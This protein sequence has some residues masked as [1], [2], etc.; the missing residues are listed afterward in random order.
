MLERPTAIDPLTLPD[1]AYLTPQDECFYFGEYSAR[2]GYTHSDTNSLILNLKK[3]VSRRGMTDYHYKDEAIAQVATAI[4]RF[5]DVG[6]VTFVP[7]P[8]SK[9]RTD[10][11]YDDRLIRILAACQRQNAQVDYR[12]LLTQTESTTAAHDGTR[13]RPDQLESIYRVQ[14]VETPLRGTVVLLDDVL[15]TGCHYVAA[16][17]SLQR[18]FPGQRIMGLFVARRVPEADDI[19]DLFEKP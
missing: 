1:H 18:F 3:P 6:S 4:L 5:V 12:E 17:N 16:R 10:P 2:R 13:P 8:P 9:S 14:P 7:I 11:A 19:E 15:T